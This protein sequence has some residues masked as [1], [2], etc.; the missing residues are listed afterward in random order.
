MAGYEKLLNDM[1]KELHHFPASTVHLKDMEDINLRAKE[2]NHIKL[3][4]Y[5]YDS[6]WN[7][8]NYRVGG[9]DGSFNNPKFPKKS[10]EIGLYFSIYKT[11][12]RF[13]NSDYDYLIWLEDDTEVMPDIMENLKEYLSHVDF[14]FDVISLGMQ[15]YQHEFY[16]E[17][18]EN[19]NNKY[20]CKVYQVFYA[21]SLMFSR[22]G[23]YKLI[24]DLD[25]NGLSYPLDWYICNIR[26]NAVDTVRFDTYNI[27]PEYPSLFNLNEDANKDSTIN[28]TSE[29]FK[30]EN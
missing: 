21:G 22:K 4:H 19:I 30:E 5:E 15:D 20:L 11:F 27:K 2:F 23:I 26:N 29:L 3:F 10:G 1:P 25:A 28:S 13:L 6:V 8:Y 16:E 7:Q 12:K 17:Y 24:S 18:L 9:N 14:D